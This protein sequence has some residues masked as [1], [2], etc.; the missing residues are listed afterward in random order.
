MSA[1]FQRNLHASLPSVVKGE[2]NYLIDE[3]GK[4]YLDACGG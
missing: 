1:L 2:G 4:R 3:T